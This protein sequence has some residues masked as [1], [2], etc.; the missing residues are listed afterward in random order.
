[1]LVASLLSIASLGAFAQTEGH[2]VC[3][4]PA[5]MPKGA[6][7]VFPKSDYTALEDPAC[8]PCYEYRSKH[9]YLVMECPYLRFAPEHSGKSEALVTQKNVIDG[10]IEV[11]SRGE[12]GGNY[13][14]VCKKFPN[15]PAGAT[16][17]FPASNYTPLQ[18]PSCP[19]CYEYKSRYGYMVMECPYLRFAPEHH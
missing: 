19:P 1:M 11:Q 7:M 10:S 3:K 15:M 2:G 6:K 9:G 4:R 16:P 17:V 18:D 8:P 12:Y 14:A 5:N 13:P